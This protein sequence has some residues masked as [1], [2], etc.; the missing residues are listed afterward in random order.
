MHAFLHTEV[1]KA[2]RKVF[3]FLVDHIGGTVGATVDGKDKLDPERFMQDGQVILSGLS[4][5]HLLFLENLADLGRMTAE[6]AGTDRHSLG[7]RERVGAKSVAVAAHATHGFTVGL[8]AHL[9]SIGAEVHVVNVRV[10]KGGV[11]RL[12]DGK[13]LGGS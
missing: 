13:S 1:A 3:D 12:G 11:A 7:Q 8:L 10:I 4:E 9:I 2:A 6:R 5:V